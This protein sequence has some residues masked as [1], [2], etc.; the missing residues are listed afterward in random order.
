[1]TSRLTTL[2]QQDP[3]ANYFL[4]TADTTNDISGNPYFGNVG[5]YASSLA[6]GLVS[7]KN[8]GAKFQELAK[9]LIDLE[10]F[11]DLQTIF[12]ATM[13]QQTVNLS[14]GWLLQDMGK[15]IE[16]VINGELALRLNLVQRVH[17]Y[18]VD[19]YSGLVFYIPTFVSLGFGSV[20]GVTFIPFVRTGA[21]PNRSESNQFLTVMFNHNGYAYKPSS[22][23]RGL[24][25]VS[26]NKYLR[27]GNSIYTKSYNDMSDV[28]SQV[29]D[30]QYI[31]I[32]QG[33]LFRDLGKTV[34]FSVNG[35][36]AIRWQ[37]C[38]LV[39]GADSEGVQDVGVDGFGNPVG[40][41][42]IPVF[43]ADQDFYDDPIVVGRTGWST[44]TTPETR[45]YVNQIGVTTYA[46]SPLTLDLA[47]KQAKQAGIPFTRDNEIVQT[48]TLQHMISLYAVQQQIQLP[49]TN[50]PLQFKDMGGNVDFLIAG[51]L[52]IRWRKVQF[53]QG[54]SSEGVDSVLPFGEND[55]FYIVTYVSD[56]DIFTSGLSP[57]LPQRVVVAKTG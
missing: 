46:H 23:E 45:F 42:Y 38:Q 25:V 26:S 17:N 31:A 5:F 22:I 33:Q 40:Q 34:D 3:A 21:T 1:M 27:V 48:D 44:N 56:P 13:S 19:G 2:R 8:N 28:Y 24:A 36:L 29:Y 9:E 55:V 11:S 15:K 39:K 6:K 51:R 30:Q 12:N 54:P 20:N 53:V 14:L 43:V 49:N 16:F 4:V 37:L 47:L 57:S 32:S 35:K 18:S 10:T 41:Y 50:I 52:A 7:A